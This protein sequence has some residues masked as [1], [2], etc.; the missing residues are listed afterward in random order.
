MAV[1]IMSNLLCSL[2]SAGLW[3]NSWEFNPIFDDEDWRIIFRHW[4]QCSRLSSRVCWPWGGFTTRWHQPKNAT[5]C[6]GQT[7]L[8]AVEDWNGQAQKCVQWIGHFV[9]WT[10]PFLGQ[11]ILSISSRRRFLNLVKGRWKFWSGKLLHPAATAPPETQAVFAARNTIGIMFCS[12]LEMVLWSK[13]AQKRFASHFRKVLN[14]IFS[15]CTQERYSMARDGVREHPNSVSLWFATRVPRELGLPV[16]YIVLGSAQLG[17]LSAARISAPRKTDWSGNKEPGKG[18][19]LIPRM[20][21]GKER[22]GCG[23]PIKWEGWEPLKDRTERQVLRTD[24]HGIITSCQRELRFL[25]FSLVRAGATHPGLTF[26]VLFLLSLH[27]VLSDIVLCDSLMTTFFDCHERCSKYP[28]D[29]RHGQAS[30]EG[31]NTKSLW[32]PLPAAGLMPRTFFFWGVS[33][34][35]AGCELKMTIVRLGMDFWLGLWKRSRLFFFQLLMNWWTHV[36]SLPESWTDGMMSVSVK[37][38]M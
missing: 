27:S 7:G 38:F 19:D 30:T 21:D 37:H 31:M 36:A 29:I 10:H 6:W 9:Q 23:S 15:C 25:F 13:D 16:K 34:K 33:P 24:H 11:S 18:S 35:S 5:H 20:T 3:I 4:R 8:E 26:D 14:T 22:C 12:G 2:N 32:L 28:L 17:N 1:R